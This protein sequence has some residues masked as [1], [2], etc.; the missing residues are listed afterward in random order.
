M[1]EFEVEVEVEVEVGVEVEVEVEVED[2]IIFYS[3]SNK[4]EATSNK[5][6][7]RERFQRSGFISD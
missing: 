4:Q 2:F 3:K 6:I 1:E 7:S 5:Q